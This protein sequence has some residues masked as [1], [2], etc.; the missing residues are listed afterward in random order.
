MI[1]PGN[2][3]V[4]WS[5][6]RGY[7]ALCEGDE[8]EPVKPYWPKLEPFAA[9]FRRFYSDVPG[10]TF[11][12]DQPWTIFEIPELRTVVAGLNSVMAETHEDHYGSCGEEQL[13]SVASALRPREAEGWL[14]IGVLHHNPVLSGADDTAALRD[15]A[16]LEALVAPRLHLLLH[17]HTHEGKIYSTGPDGMPVLC[18]GSAG[19]RQ[20][21]RPMTCQTS[22][23]W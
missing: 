4:S 8:I 3:D 1:V 2:H 17:G 16:M 21:A 9:M 6:C 23:S 18:A 11:P 5:K 19:V 20:D 12:P 10:A 15:A 13:R 22:T 7:F 14:R